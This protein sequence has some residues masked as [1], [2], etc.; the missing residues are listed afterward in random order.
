MTASTPD[1][2]QNV[3]KGIRKALC[4]ACLALGSAGDDV[5][6][7]EAARALLRDALHFVAHHGENED[8]LL[9][10][11]VEARAPALAD[12]L[13][14]EHAA[15]GNALAAL[16]AALEAGSSRALYA[17]LCA[18]MADYFRHMHE[19]EHTHEPKI[20][21]ALS[22]EELSAF[23]RGSVERTAPDD[24]LMMLGFMLPAL[25]AVDAEAFLARLPPRVAERLR[26]LVSH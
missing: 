5:S 16:N 19:E 7:T 15:L 1:I 22:S 14:R 10:P 26:P 11:L 24:Q 12:T 20:R 17:A 6:R 25:A 18:F 2:F 9:L 23:A 13:R 4:D 3:H 21:A 8:L